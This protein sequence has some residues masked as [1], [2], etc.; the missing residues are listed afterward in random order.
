VIP[1]KI[2]EDKIDDGNVAPNEMAN[3]SSSFCDSVDA[4]AETFELVDGRTS[5]DKFDDQIKPST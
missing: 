2:E 3:S 1:P 5:D 4:K